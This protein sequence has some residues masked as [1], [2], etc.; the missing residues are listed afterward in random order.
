MYEAGSTEGLGAFE[1]AEFTE[2]TQPFSAVSE[3]AVAALAG[4]PAAA[5]VS[6]SASW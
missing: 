6:P 3:A 1:S 5:Y 4:A 2:E